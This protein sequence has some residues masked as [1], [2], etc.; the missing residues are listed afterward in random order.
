MS[1][2]LQLRQTN[3]TKTIKNCFNFTS[4]TTIITNKKMFNFPTKSNN[5][6]SIGWWKGEEKEEMKKMDVGIL[7]S[8]LLNNAISIVCII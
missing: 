6:F 5:S 8:F 3:K 7:S 2:Y 4:P 1:K